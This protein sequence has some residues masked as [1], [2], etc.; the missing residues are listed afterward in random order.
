[1]FQENRKLR[2]K[3]NEEEKATKTKVKDIID[4]SLLNEIESKQNLM[5]EVR[6]RYMK[7]WKD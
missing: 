4:Q 1:M 5:K 3:K 6:E 2:N 7:E